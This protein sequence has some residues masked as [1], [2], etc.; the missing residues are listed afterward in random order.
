MSCNENFQCRF[1]GSDK[2]NFDAT[3]PSLSITK[4]YPPQ[5]RETKE[6]SR[7]CGSHRI[8]DT[9][10]LRD[11]LQE[12][13]MA[14]QPKA[15]K[16]CSTKT[17]ALQDGGQP[18]EKLILE[19]ESASFIK[20]D[21]DSASDLS[22]SERVAIPSSPL[23]PPDLNLKAEQIEPGYFHYSLVPEDGKYKYPDF[24]PAPFNSW[25]LSHLATY[26]NTEGKPT[27]PTATSGSLERYINRLLQLEWLQMQTVQNE[28]SKASK[29]RTPTTSSISRLGKHPGKPKAWHTPLP[30]KQTMLS[31]QF[32]RCTDAPH[33]SCNKGHLCHDIPVQRGMQRSN[34]LD[35][36]SSA[37]RK[38]QNVTVIPKNRPVMRCQPNKDLLRANSPKIQSLGNLRPPKQTPCTRAP[39]SSSKPVKG[40]TFG[41]PRSSRLS[42]SKLLLSGQPA[43]DQKYKDNSLRVSSFKGK[44]R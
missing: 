30:V 18:I 34:D 43:A 27:L 22:D 20:D 23:A 39:E 38:A 17:S 15:A 19:F 32:I 37:R 42:S 10:G 14:D 24:L 25:N 1:R 13:S 35:G 29:S 7:A 6:S 2:A 26:V 40:S 36:L 41:D 9:V 33:N 31:D 21:E 3:Q 4:L 16:A 11:G 12:M 5:W 28:K 44:P 8:P